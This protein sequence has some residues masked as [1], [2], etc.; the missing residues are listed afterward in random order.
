MYVFL[1]TRGVSL[2]VVSRGMLFIVVHGLLT[3]V[4]SLVVEH[5]L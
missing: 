4:I 1:A 2:V 3:A 5:T